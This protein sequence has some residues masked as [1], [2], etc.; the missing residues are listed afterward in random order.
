MFDL[1]VELGA[2]QNHDC[3][4]PGGKS[5][6]LVRN[7]AGGQRTPPMQPNPETTSVVPFR[8]RMR[9]TACKGGTVTILTELLANVRRR[10]GAREPCTSAVLQPTT[11]ARSRT[12]ALL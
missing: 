1:G 11:M 6:L 3:G 5:F 9:G 7:K 2:K 4:S 12:T 8:P 10:R